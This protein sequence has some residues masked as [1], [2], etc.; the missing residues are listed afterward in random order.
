MRCQST[1]HF[2]RLWEEPRV[3]RE[4]P[5]MH[6]ENIQMSGKKTMAGI[7][8]QNTPNKGTLIKGEFAQ[9][10]VINAHVVCTGT[11]INKCVVIIATGISRITTLPSVEFDTMKGCVSNNPFE[12]SPDAHVET[13]T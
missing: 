3:P 13:P 5:H 4:N 11:L 6:R 12:M 7:Q 8:N 9:I 2:F 1:M 10:F